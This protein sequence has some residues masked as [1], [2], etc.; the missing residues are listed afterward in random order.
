MRIKAPTTSNNAE[1][2]CGWHC[3][4]VAVFDFFYLDLAS[5]RQ[6]SGVPCL[7]FRMAE[8]W[9][10]TT[11]D[12][13]KRIPLLTDNAGPRDSKEKWDIRLKQVQHRTRELASQ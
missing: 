13:V 11:K 12:T 4:P 9:D 2:L 5:L 10:N 6:S 3:A 8:S 1:N 7:S